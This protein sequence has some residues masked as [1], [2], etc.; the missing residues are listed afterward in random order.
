MSNESNDFMLACRAAG[1][2]IP[3]CGLAIWDLLQELRG[4]PLEATAAAFGGLKMPKPAR[5]GVALKH[6]L[7]RFDPATR[8]YAITPAGETW[9]TELEIG[10]KKPAQKPKRGI[11]EGPIPL[12]EKQCPGWKVIAG[13]LYVDSL[14]TEKRREDR[15]FARTVLD[16]QRRAGTPAKLVMFRGMGFVLRSAEGWKYKDK[17]LKQFRSSVKGEPLSVWEV[18]KS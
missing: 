11:G 4:G 17:A 10:L 6:G 8:M 15:T 12:V 5:M 16:E 18:R 7:V 1:V 3:G 9:L 14:V 2:Y 13:P